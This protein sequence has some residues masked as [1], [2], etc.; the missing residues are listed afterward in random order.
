MGDELDVIGVEEATC[1]QI[2]EYVTDV[3]DKSRRVYDRAL[4]NTT[5]GCSSLAQGA[6]DA[7]IESLTIE[8]WNNP[9]YDSGNDAI[10]S[11]LSK[12]EPVVNRIE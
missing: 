3:V 6:T 1:S 10:F 5:F 8:V 11:K 12:Y 9:I 4:G 2:I 7:Y